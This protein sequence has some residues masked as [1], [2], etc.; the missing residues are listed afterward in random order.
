[1]KPADLQSHHVG[2]WVNLYLEG[3][4]YDQ[5]QLVKIVC[6]DVLELISSQQRPDQKTCLVYVSAVDNPYVGPSGWCTWLG[7]VINP[8]QIELLQQELQL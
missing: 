4:R 7:P 5:M 2:N 3:K 1:M 8:F 6:V